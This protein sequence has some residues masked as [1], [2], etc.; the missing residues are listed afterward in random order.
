MYIYIYIYIYQHQNNILS[1]YTFIYISIII[2]LYVYIHLWPFVS[3]KEIQNFA[4]VPKRPFVSKKV[5]G[6]VGTTVKLLYFLVVNGHECIYSYNIIMML[7]FFITT[8]ISYLTMY[9]K[10]LTQVFN[11]KA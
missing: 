7:I 9:C 3:Y 2:I 5:N 1:I 11:I 8:T 4:V 6:R 10:I